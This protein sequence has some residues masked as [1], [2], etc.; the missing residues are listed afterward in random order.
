L[1]APPP[2]SAANQKLRDRIVSASGW[3]RANLP[4]KDLIFI[5]FWS[6]WTYLNDTFA[7]Y[8]NSVH[9]SMV[10][11]VDPQDDAALMAKAP[12]LWAWASVN[13][14]FH[15][16]PET[17]N[18][19]L[20]ELRSAFSK[21]LLER[22]LRAAATGFNAMRPGVPVPATD[23]NGMSLDDLYAFRS[24]FTENTEIFSTGHVDGC[25]GKSAFASAQCGRDGEWF[26]LC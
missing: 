20:E 6:D 22:V 4:E 21:N 23:F 14:N 9:G 24:V 5:G 25:R 1:N 10:I 19:F 12:A 11:L 26:T 17:G 7:N 8:F 16:V 15:H 3:L 13:A 18:E 2:V